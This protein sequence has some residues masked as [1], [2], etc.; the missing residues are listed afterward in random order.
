[1]TARAFWLTE[2][3]SRCLSGL[4]IML[5]EGADFQQV[6]K[7]MEA[8]GL[9]M[10]PAYLMDV[11]GIDTINHCYPVLTN[12]LPERFSKGDNWP[13]DIIFKANRLGQK[14]GLGYYKYELNEKGKPAK[15]VDPD[16]VAMFEA[17]FGPAKLFDQQ[18]IE[19][20]LM[21]PM[22]MEMIHCL[23]EGI[24]ASPSEAD[25][26][27]IYRCWLSRFSTVVSVV[28]WM[29]RVWLRLLSVPINIRSSVNSTVPQKSYVRWQLMG[30]RFTLSLE[31][32]SGLPNIGARL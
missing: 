18:E 1:M 27:L 29:S 10:G 24:V 9:P 32:I 20:R 31:N 6:D 8:W 3:F 15:L 12:G 7:V 17:E 22:A 25:M 2:C 28:G 14:N 26:A 4:E 13:T 19:D 16:V 21:L 11:V 23:E 30:S 5:S